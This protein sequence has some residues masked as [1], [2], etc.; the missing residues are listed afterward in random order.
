MFSKPVFLSVVAMFL[1]G[2]WT[3]FSK[4]AT[5]SLDSTIVMAVSY[6]LGGGIALL[7]LFWAGDTYI[8][9]TPGIYYAIAGGILAG[10]GGIS[11]YL[12]LSIGKTA[13]VAP[14]GGL[15]FVVAA[16]IGIIFLGESMNPLNIAGIGFAG[17]AV[18]LISL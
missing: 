2:V 5:D 1:W 16:A 10:M 4:L 6:L 17:L 9:K 12:A 13:L 11:Y 18:Y 3:V 15:Y 7:Y 8:V 14:I